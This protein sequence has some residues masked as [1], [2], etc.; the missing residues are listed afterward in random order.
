MEEEYI[1]KS[2][3]W[4]AKQSG[5]EIP[6]ETS[7]LVSEQDY[8]SEMDPYSQELNCPVVAIYKETDWMNACEKCMN[9]LANRN[10]GHSLSIYSKDEKIIREFANKKPVGRI[11]INVNATYGSMG[12]DTD[13]EPSII[14]G[15]FT[16]GKGVLSSNLSVKHLVYNRKIGKGKEK[17]LL[18]N[19]N[20]SK[21]SNIDFED[22][23]KSISDLSGYKEE[24]EESDKLKDLV[25]GF[26]KLLSEMKN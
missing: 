20:N 21:K 24:K 14:L 7:I 5:F 2:A 18:F 10:G 16:R 15:S 9:L 13:L 23:L 6:E 8:V 12:I 3:H 25:K 1:G 19:E 17:T 4:L 11:L 26:A 22:I